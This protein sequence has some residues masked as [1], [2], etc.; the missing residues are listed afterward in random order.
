MSHELSALLLTECIQHSTLDMKI[1]IYTLFLDA[2]SAFDFVLFEI[3]GRRLYLDG[4][5]DQNLS[6]ILRRLENRIT[7]CDWNKDLMGPIFD[8]QGLEQ[9]GVNSSDLYKVV[10]NEQLTV[11]HESD[12][13]SY[14][15][16]TL[17]TKA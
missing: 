15:H 13:V 12:S 8:E 10:N 6:F 17:P 16:L 7:F 1:P 2:K 14:T 9:G 3:L 4:T 11:P 5:S